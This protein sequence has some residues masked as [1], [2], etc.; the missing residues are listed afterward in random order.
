MA[1]N[2]LEALKAQCKLICNTCYVDDDVARLMLLNAGIE[3]GGLP[4][5]N[6][7]DIVKA[8]ILIVKGWVET[9]RTENGISASVDVASVK[10]NIV[11]WCGQSGLDA[12]EYVDDLIVIDNGSNLW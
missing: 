11:F 4:T 5:A 2:N 8:A 10:K 12:S 6:N 7:P 9:S 3:E 1:K